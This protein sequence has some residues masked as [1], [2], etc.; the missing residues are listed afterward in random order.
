MESHQATVGTPHRAP[1][2]ASY[3]ASACNPLRRSRLRIGGS[4]R[5]SS[6]CAPTSSVAKVARFGSSAGR[7]TS[8]SC[9]WNG[10]A[11]W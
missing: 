7:W 6:T 11:T 8:L 3:S 2:V 5:S 1:D 4:V 9:W 10:A